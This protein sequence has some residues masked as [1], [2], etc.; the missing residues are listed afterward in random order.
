MLLF[1]SEPAVEG[2]IFWGF[3]DG[4]LWEQ[5]AALFTGANVTVRR[6][7]NILNVYL[8]VM[9]VGVQWRSYY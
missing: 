5:D 9:V 7:S 2:V 3:W 1:L 4:Q 8:D 6:L